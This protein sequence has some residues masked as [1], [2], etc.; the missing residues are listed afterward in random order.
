MR[1]CNARAVAGDSQ[2]LR[3]DRAEV[4]VSS[5]VAAELWT[6]VSK[7][8][9]PERSRNAVRAFLSYVT[10]LYWP[11]EAAATYGALRARLETSGR[12]IGAIDLLIAAH[13]VHEKAILVTRNQSEFRR[14]SG[15][16]V[17]SWT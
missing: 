15:L 9:H 10:V 8:I 6:G 1:G 2:S 13:A 4:A 16:R 5:I 11:A 17:E 7:S 3:T 12:S 14:V